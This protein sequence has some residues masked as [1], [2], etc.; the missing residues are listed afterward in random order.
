M[1]SENLF[2]V[3]EMAAK[4]KVE[5]RFIYLHTKTGTLPHHRIGRSIRF[6]DGDFRAILE[7]SAC[8]VAQ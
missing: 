6:T 8:G 2:T 7:K 3:D 4:L 5:K 1:D